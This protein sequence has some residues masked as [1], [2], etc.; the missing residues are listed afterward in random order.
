[1]R[2]PMTRPPHD[3]MSSG[4]VGRS[5]ATISP[6]PR[7]APTTVAPR[8]SEPV[9]R[10]AATTTSVAPRNASVVR[11]K[12]SGSTPPFKFTS[13]RRH[14]NAIASITARATSSAAKAR[15]LDRRTALPLREDVVRHTVDH[16]VRAE[17]G[18]YLAHADDQDAVVRAAKRDRRVGEALAEPRG[19]DHKRRAPRQAAALAKKYRLRRA[20]RIRA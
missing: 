15:E 10:R 5:T 8:A 12:A 6:T 4:R 7:V 11:I 1:M 16:Q 20:H 18:G 19:D 14:A 2:K 13:A 17:C 9:S 3:T